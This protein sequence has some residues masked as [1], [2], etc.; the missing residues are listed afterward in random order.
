M[1]QFLSLAL[2]WYQEFSYTDSL[3]SQLYTSEKEKPQSS[4]SQQQSA[5]SIQSE[6]EKLDDFSEVEQAVLNREPYVYSAAH[7]TSLCILRYLCCC[8]KKRDWFQK[9]VRN[10]KMNSEIEAG[11]STQMDIVEILKWQRVFKFL[12]IASLR[13]NQVQLVKYFRDFN[14]QKTPGGKIEGSVDDADLS[15]EEL[16]RNFSPYDDN[17]DKVLLYMLTGR[18]LDN[19]MKDWLGEGDD[20]DFD[21]G[22]NTS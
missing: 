3:S 15:L 4:R 10:D 20:I 7:R 22:S 17:V 6:D 19:V 9:R 16:M 12:T 11:L 8:L 13:K 2:S 1:W 14:I 5:S 18:N 21:P